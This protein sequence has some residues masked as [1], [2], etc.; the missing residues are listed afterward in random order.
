M[1][2][3]L[4]P[5][6]AVSLLNWHGKPGPSAIVFLY[7]LWFHVVCSSLLRPGHVMCRGHRN[8][9]HMDRLFCALSIALF[10]HEVCTSH[11]SFQTVVFNSEVKRMQYAMFSKLTVF[12]GQDLFIYGV[13]CEMP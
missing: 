6:V 2:A 12:P 13:C 3:L 5:A 10:C 4:T 7:L 8:N 9:Y 11:K 1:V